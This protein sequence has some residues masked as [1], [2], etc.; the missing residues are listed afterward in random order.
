MEKEQF[1][2]CAEEEREPPHALEDHVVV[3]GELAADDENLADE[4]SASC[5]AEG[6][7][8]DRVPDP[9]VGLEHAVAVDAE[10]PEWTVEAVED[11]SEHAQDE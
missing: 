6:G 8:E 11:H 2:P 4:E 10:E 7:D 3:V 1:L 9:D 5:G